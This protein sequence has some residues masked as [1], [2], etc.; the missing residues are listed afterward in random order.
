MATHCTLRSFHRD[1]SLSEFFPSNSKGVLTRRMDANGNAAPERR[2]RPG[3]CVALRT[4]DQHAIFVEKG[5]EVVD[6]RVTDRM[7]ALVVQLWTAQQ[8]R[9]YVGL[10]KVINVD[11]VN[12]RLKDV[13]NKKTWIAVNHTEYVDSDMVKAGI[14]DDEF[15][16]R[17]ELDEEFILFTGDGPEPDLAD[18]ERPHTYIFVER[19]SR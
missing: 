18:R 12:A 19:R 3:A 17:M 10:N 1:S 2:I 7:L 13:S 11:Y 6:G 8:L 16:A 4:F 14:T 5:R 9:A 15:N